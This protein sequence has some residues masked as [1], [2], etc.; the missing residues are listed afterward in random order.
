MGSHNI[1]ESI[2]S[3]IAEKRHSEGTMMYSIIISF[4]LVFFIA[5]LVKDFHIILGIRQQ[6]KMLQ[7]LQKMWERTKIK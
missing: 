7:W 5:S 3:E 6:I 1:S 2:Y 4:G